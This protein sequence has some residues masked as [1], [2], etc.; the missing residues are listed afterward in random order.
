MRRHLSV[1]THEVVTNPSLKTIPLSVSSTCQTGLFVIVHK[2][3][4]ALHIPSTPQSHKDPSYYHTKH[5]LSAF[6]LP[7][8]PN[9][10]LKILCGELLQ[11]YRHGRLNPC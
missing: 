9:L 6:V 7:A 2:A 5:S 4:G 10:Y 8:A 11:E 1:R 3:K